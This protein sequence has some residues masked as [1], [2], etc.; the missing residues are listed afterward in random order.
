[1]GHNDACPH[2][3]S[4]E[5]IHSRGLEKDDRRQSVGCPFFFFWFRFF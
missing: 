3:F 2:M 5:G 1:M 4:A